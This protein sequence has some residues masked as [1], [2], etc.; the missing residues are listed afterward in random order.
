MALKNKGFTLVELMITVSIVGILASMAL[1]NFNQIISEHRL[2]QGVET[3]A[4]VM[5]KA[6]ARAVEISSPVTVTVTNTAVITVNGSVG[7]LRREMPVNIVPSGTVMFVFAPDGRAST[8]GTLILNSSTSASVPA[9]T[10]IVTAIGQIAVA[11]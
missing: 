10:L 1:P 11:Y 4:A 6:Q 5:R 3:A 9:K 2:R 7:A 8:S